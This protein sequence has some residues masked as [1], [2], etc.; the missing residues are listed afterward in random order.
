MPLPGAR[1]YWPGAG[2]YQAS[3]FIGPVGDAGTKKWN[4]TGTVTDT[5]TNPQ[6]GFNVYAFAIVSGAPSYMGAAVTDVNGSWSIPV[7]SNAY[8]YFA[9][10]SN[11]SNV[12]SVGVTSFNLIPS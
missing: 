2:P 4:L 5:L 1:N 10:S 8:P 11:P 7:V 3:R 9:V 6:A 12:T